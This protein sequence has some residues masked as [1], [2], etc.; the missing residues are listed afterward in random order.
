MNYLIPLISLAL[1]AGPAAA[2]PARAA[3]PSGQPGHPAASPAGPSL[4]EIRSEAKANRAFGVRL[5]KQLAKEPGNVF[6]SPVSIAAAFGPV[7]AGARGETAT[8]VGRALGFRPD[9]KLLPRRVG[10]LLRALR[11]EGDGAKVSIANALWVTERHPLKPA[12]VADVRSEFD[13]TAETLDFVK[14]ARAAQR[15]NAWAESETNGKIKNLFGEDAFDDATALVVT[16]AVH[17]LGDW[18]EPF[19]AFYT[20]QE[21]FFLP[22]GEQ[23]ELAMMS[24]EKSAKYFADDALQ[25]I[26]LPYKGGALSMVLILPRDRDGLPALEEQ[27]SDAKL[28]EWLRK[29]DTSTP[30]DVVQGVMVQLPKV[31]IDNDYNLGDPLKTL[32]MGLAFDRLKANFGGMS[33]KQLFI[34]EA[35]HKTF[36][37]IDE[38]GTEAAAATA[39]VMGAERSGPELLFRADHPFL[40]LIR[41]KNSGAILFMGRI[42]QP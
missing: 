8:A 34:S 38:K 13:S 35:L 36:L 16:N 41:D 32:G 24:G 29:L 31:E 5:Y 9:P 10:G 4:E 40:A 26:D 1:A 2:Q 19:N 7:A 37:R 17:F 6:I 14:S 30:P 12:F 25:M 3:E 39:V 21:P 15:I 27:L 42:A 20:R 22:G 28:G 18:A 23:R 11:T 33:D